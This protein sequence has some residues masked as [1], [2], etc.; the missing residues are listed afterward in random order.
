MNIED[1]DLKSIRAT[2]EELSTKL[3]ELRGHL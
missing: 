3:D 2:F 1:V